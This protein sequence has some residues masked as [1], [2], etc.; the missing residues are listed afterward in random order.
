MF[1]HIFYFLVF[2]GNISICQCFNVAKTIVES[3][4]G[5]SESKKFTILTKQEKD[6][7]HTCHV[8]GSFEDGQMQLIDEK[9]I[10]QEI[11]F[12]VSHLLGREIEVYEVVHAIMNH[13]LVN[14]MGLPGVGKTALA[15]N[16][17]NFIAD[18]RLFKLGIIFFSC[19]G[20]RSTSFFMK[21]LVSNIIIN[22][23]ELE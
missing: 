17:I 2:L 7:S 1:A 16:A 13:R 20:F 8:I 18:R 15:K 6:K 22:N 10:F 11:P 23:V 5:L 12:K 9:P 21:K 14:I 19:S 3:K 4:F